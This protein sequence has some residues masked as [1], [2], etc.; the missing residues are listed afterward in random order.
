MCAL[1]L[2]FIIFNTYLLMQMIYVDGTKCEALPMLRKR[3]PTITW[4]MEVLRER[5]EEEI[6][7]GG[8]GRGEIETAYMEEDDMGFPEDLDVITCLHKILIHVYFYM[9]VD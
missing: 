9:C 4:S 5:E 7:A 8:L 6:D 2:W 1:V 3:P